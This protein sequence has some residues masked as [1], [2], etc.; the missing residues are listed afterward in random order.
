M[1]A[2]VKNEFLH[3][4]QGHRQHAWGHDALRPLSRWPTDCI[5]SGEDLENSSAGDAMS[6]PGDMETSGYLEA[7]TK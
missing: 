7:L 2:D 1:A 3:A 4:W 6:L 5:G